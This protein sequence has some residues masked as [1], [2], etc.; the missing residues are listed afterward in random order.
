MPGKPKR[1]AKH[2]AS[3][4]SKTIVRQGVAAPPAAGT[5]AAEPVARAPAAASPARPSRPAAAPAGIG[6]GHYPYFIPEL[7][8][9]GILSVIIIVILVV[10]SL[11]LS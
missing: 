8:R 9:I 7:K 4:K 1:K 6:T 2:P 5:A 3:K 10:L 11:V